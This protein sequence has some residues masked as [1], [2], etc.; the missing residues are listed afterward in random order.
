MRIIAL[1]TGGWMPTVKHETACYIC[2][3][4]DVLYMFDCG[5]GV[6]KLF[7]SKYTTILESYEKI[8]IV[9]SHYHL[10]HLLGLFYIHKLLFTLTDK[11]IVLVGPENEHYKG[12]IKKQI[13][14]LNKQGIM[15][16]NLRENISF[17]GY[18]DGSRIDLF[19]HVLSFKE[20]KHSNPSYRAVLDSLFVYATDTSE[21]DNDIPENAFLLHECWDNSFN[22]I[23]HT[24]FPMIQDLSVCRPDL[25]IGL[26]HFNPFFSDD[27][28]R[29]YIE[30]CDNNVFIV[31]DENEYYL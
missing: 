16:I 23:N 27:C 7:N 18:T 3:T 22:N 24:T 5:S 2:L 10:D 6:K 31:D 15:N 14:C 8:V 13:D 21:I 29:D 9:F 12:G 30:M 20:Q 25:R 4:D 1:G 11:R 28:L 26:V 17:V 19:G